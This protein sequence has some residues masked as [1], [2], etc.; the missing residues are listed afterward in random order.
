MTDFSVLGRWLELMLPGLSV[1][2]HMSILGA[3]G[4]IALGLLLGIGA[5]SPMPVYRETCRFIIDTVRS[6][7]ILA[8]MFFLYYGLG[9]AEIMGHISAFYLAVL[10]L[11]IVTAGYLGDVYKACLLSAPNG[12]WEA[13]SSLGFTRTRTLWLIILPQV[14]PSMIPGTMNMVA[15]LIK[16][17]SLASLITVPEL[18]MTASRAVSES[19]QPMQV[20]LLL[21][22]L[23]ALIIIPMLLLVRWLETWMVAR[24]TRRQAVLAAVPSAAH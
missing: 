21:A 16:G 7:P 14:F 11:G 10:S 23:Y 6:L 22:A 18:T 19:F 20:Y 15:M 8:V 12:Q 1:T 24:A 9:S 3:I 13:G 5:A 17:T 2:L 4:S